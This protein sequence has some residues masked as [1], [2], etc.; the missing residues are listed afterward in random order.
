VVF[1]HSPEGI[2][3]YAEKIE[4]MLGC[5]SK[6]DRLHS[7]YLLYISKSGKPPQTPAEKLGAIRNFIKEGKMMRV[8]LYGQP[9]GKF[10]STCI[11]L[12]VAEVLLAKREGVISNVRFYSNLRSPVHYLVA[13]NEGNDFEVTCINRSIRNKGIIFRW[14]LKAESVVRHMKYVDAIGKRLKVT[15]ALSLVKRSDFSRVRSA[16]A[17]A[18]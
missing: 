8:H 9:P 17:Q 5:K 16:M 7:E 15:S 13:D 18:R 12:S 10:G 14:N 1:V 3:N 11:E 2:E 6:V 4:I